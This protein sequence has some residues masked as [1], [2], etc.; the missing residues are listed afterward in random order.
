MLNTKERVILNNKLKIFRKAKGMSQVEM[1]KIINKTERTY[2]HY[3]AGERVPDVFT[4]IRIADFYG[5][6][7]LREL[8]KLGGENSSAIHKHQNNTTKGVRK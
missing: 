1:S 5:I 3:E 4:A 8:F 2:R 7:D 6:K